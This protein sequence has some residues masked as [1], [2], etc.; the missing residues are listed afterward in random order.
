MI[1]Q[2]EDA[3]LKK[4]QYEFR[5]VWEENELLRMFANMPLFRILLKKWNVRTCSLPSDDKW[6][7]VDNFILECEEYL[8]VRTAA[9][10]LKNLST[11]YATRHCGLT[12][13]GLFFFFF[14][15]F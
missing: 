15:C 10:D 6:A 5:W 14:F 9:G 4:R 13:P 11:D 2:Y 3:I 8:K 7:E 1:I 12:E